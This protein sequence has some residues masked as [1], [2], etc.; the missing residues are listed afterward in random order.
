MNRR[1]SSGK[2]HHHT[3][4]SSSGSSFHSQHRS[5][6]V[7]LEYLLKERLHREMQIEQVQARIDGLGQRGA[8]LQAEQQ[9]HMSAIPLGIA[10][11]A[12]STLGMRALPPIARHWYL[13]HQRLQEAEQHLRHE[14]LMLY[15]Q[16]QALTQEIELLNIEIDMQKY[17]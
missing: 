13:K 2:H 1:H 17:Y 5:G 10:Q 16:L 15:A 14:A 6:R 8:M 4:H 12:L 7:S 11:V 3:S 9:A